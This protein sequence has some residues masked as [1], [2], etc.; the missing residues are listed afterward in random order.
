MDGKREGQAQAIAVAPGLDL[1]GLT[2][3]LRFR[4]GFGLHRG[5]GV[6][7]SS[8]VRLDRS[9]AQS[10][11]SLAGASADFGASA[12]GAGGF[13]ASAAG[14]GIAFFAG[15]AAAGS[16]GLAASAACAGWSGAASGLAASLT[17]PGHFLGRLGGGR[18]LGCGS[19]FG[20]S[21]AAGAAAGFSALRLRLHLA[22]DGLRG[23]R[24]DLFRMLF[25]RRFLLR[26][27]RPTGALAR[28]RRSAGPAPSPCPTAGR[29]RR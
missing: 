8:P 18:T 13:G 9:P 2:G 21:V 7:V 25:G 24:R 28:H 29:R 5:P 22:R 11:P 27:L 3:R 15:S 14:A 6:P 26:L 12:A 19:A 10:M 20:V 17:D 4:L 16:A 1:H 23:R